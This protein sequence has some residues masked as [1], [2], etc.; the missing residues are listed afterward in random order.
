M[1]TPHAE[2]IRALVQR[3]SQ[4]LRGISG[5]QSS[6]RRA[7]GKWSRKEVLG[8][9]ID[10]ALNNHQR[11]VRA[12]LADTLDFPAYSQNDWV[13]SQGYVDEDWPALVTLWEAL[14]RHVAHV[15][16]R[17]PKEKLS[18]PCRIGAGDPVTLDALVADYL[19]HVNHHLEQI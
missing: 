2:S 16:E 17:I 1:G 14:N 10:S 19:R 3:E 4:R 9:L 11:I 15:V 7:P 8:H 12:R 13:S 5:E 6:A 18:V